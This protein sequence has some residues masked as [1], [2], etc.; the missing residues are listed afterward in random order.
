MKR[1]FFVLLI[2]AVLAFCSC[3]SSSISSETVTND[4]RETENIIFS[5]IESKLLGTWEM[6][7]NGNT[8]NCVFEEGG[9]GRFIDNSGKVFEFKYRVLNGSQIEQT[10]VTIE[11]KEDTSIYDFEFKDDKLIFDGFEYSKQ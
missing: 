6:T 8:T 9:K 11:G 5:Q 1:F 3:E 7:F 4:N 2:I 10:M